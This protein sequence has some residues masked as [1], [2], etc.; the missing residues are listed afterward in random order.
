MKRSKLSQFK[1]GSYFELMPSDVPV[2]K[3]KWLR[4]KNG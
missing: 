3:R 1:E 2:K 4:R